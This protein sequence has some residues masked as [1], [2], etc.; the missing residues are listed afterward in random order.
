MKSAFTGRDLISLADLSKREIEEVLQVAASIKKNGAPED[1]LKGKILASCFFEPS[2]RTRLSFE[3]AMLRLGGSVIGF[4]EGSSTSSQKGESISD[5]MR[6]ISNLCDLIVI[7]HS[8]EG[9]ARAAADAAFKPVVNAGDGAN[10][11]PT[12]TLLDLFT[13]RELHGKIDDLQIAMLGDL[14]YSRT[15][16]SL[17]MGLM[18]YATRLYFISSQDPSLPEEIAESLRKAGVKFSYHTDLSEVL[19]KLDI[20]YMTRRQTERSS[21]PEKNPFVL[22]KNHLEKAKETL[23]IMH[24]LPRVDEIDPLIDA[25]P[26]AAYFQQAANGLPI[27]QAILSLILGGL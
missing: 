9:S 20:L 16:H 13:I 11:H 6:V 27:R 7:R 10:Q 14:R 8:R 21:L 5:S 3:A 25:L 23:R 19:P 18:H 15:V 1:L 26:Q 24:P 22:R 4:S 2:T 12:Q 17:A